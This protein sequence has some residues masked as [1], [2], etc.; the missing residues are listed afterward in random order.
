MADFLQLCKDTAR[1]CLVPGVGPTSTA[2]QTGQA[3]FIVQTVKNS[4]TE[5]QNEQ[6]DWRWLRSEFTVQT[7][8]NTD[9]YAYGALTDSIGSAVITRFARWWTGEFQIYLTS[10]G[11]GSRHHIPYLKWAAFRATWLTGSHPASYPS[12]VSIDPRDKLRLGAKPNAVYTF[13][14][15]YQKSPQV[16]AADGD[17]PEMPNRFHNLIVYRA[18]KRFA[19]RYGAPEIWDSAHD[20]EGPLLL[21]LEVDQKPEPEFV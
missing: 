8:A 17:I 13:T 2:N 4:Y 18:M 3:G 14:G 6:P 19:G 1:E 11:I 20:M 16:L 15:E 5:L 10:S 12:A 21:S 7:V 9:S